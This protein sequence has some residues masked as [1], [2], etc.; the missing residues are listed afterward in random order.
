MILGWS[1]SKSDDLRV[2]ETAESTSLFSS[3]PRAKGFITVCKQ[4]PHFG[5]DKNVVDDDWNAKA[6]K[7]KE[8]A[9]EA[10]K[11]QQELSSR[12]QERASAGTTEQLDLVCLGF[13]VCR[14]WHW[15]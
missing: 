3:S 13:K 6:A 9:L 1:L 15:E 8:M 12:H 5:F 10:K 7:A 4:I 11:R 2:M 14:S